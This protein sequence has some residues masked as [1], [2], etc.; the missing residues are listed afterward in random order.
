[1]THMLLCSLV[2]IHIQ[3]RSHNGASVLHVG[4]SRRRAIDR[5]AHAPYVWFSATSFRNKAPLQTYA[6]FNLELISR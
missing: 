4:A 6:K 1:M 3:N 5:L 2:R